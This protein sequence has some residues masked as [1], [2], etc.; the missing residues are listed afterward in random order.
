MKLNL[1]TFCGQNII[2]QR[3]SVLT[4]DFINVFKTKKKTVC[5]IFWCC[6]LVYIRT[7]RHAFYPGRGVKHRGAYYT[8]YIHFLP[9]MLYISSM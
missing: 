9:F 7:Y 8:M 4:L 2:R 3:Y 5:D 6:L 1:E